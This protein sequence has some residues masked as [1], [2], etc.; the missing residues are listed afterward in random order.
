MKKGCFL[1]AV[2]IFTVLLGAAFFI[3]RNYGDQLLDSAK[4]VV[5]NFSSDDIIDSID[6]IEDNQYKDSLEVVVQEYL[7]QLKKKD[8]DEAVN[9]ANDFFE[10]IEFL[11]HDGTVD[12]SD[13]ILLKKYL[14]EDEEQEES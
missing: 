5:I 8:F 2:I 4:E 3:I 11:V 13:I 10:R 14:R 6:E 7:D 12:S 9:E 1:T